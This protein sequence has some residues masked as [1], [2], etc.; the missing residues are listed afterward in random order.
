MVNAYDARTAGAADHVAQKRLAIL[1]RAAPEIMAVE[2]QQVER[3]VGELLGTPSGYG[4]AQ[5]IYVGDAAVVRHR[6][7]AVKNHGRQSGLDQV[8]EWFA[9]QRGAVATV[10]AQ[11]ASA[12]RRLRSRLTGVRHA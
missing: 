1:N 8:Q 12:S 10:A 2:V 4:L 9:E 5:R 3:E 7:L 11:A 6:D